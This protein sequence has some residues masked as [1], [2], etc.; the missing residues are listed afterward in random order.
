V[1]PTNQITEIL[2]GQGGITGDTASRLGHFFGTS[3]ESWLNLQKLYQR[4][5]AEEKAES[6]SRGLPTLPRPR[7]S[8]RAEQ[9]RTT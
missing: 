9:P 2:K 7:K 6:R 4:R 3:A 1:V 5:Q 8:A